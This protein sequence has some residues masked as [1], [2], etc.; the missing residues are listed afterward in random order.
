MFFFVR[1][2]YAHIRSNQ[3]VT[4]W[5]KAFQKKFVKGFGPILKYRS[6]RSYTNFLNKIY[7]DI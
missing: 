3:A 5:T 1:I 4:N 2:L 7:I 6:Y